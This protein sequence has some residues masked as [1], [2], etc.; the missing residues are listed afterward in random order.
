MILALVSM[1]V[2]AASSSLLYPLPPLSAETIPRSLDVMSDVV[3]QDTQRRAIDVE[4]SAQRSVITYRLSVDED[5]ALVDTVRSGGVDNDPAGAAYLT[6]GWVSLGADT[7]RDELTDAATIAGPVAVTWAPPQAQRTTSGWDIVFVAYQNERSPNP[8]ALRVLP[9]EA[10]PESDDECTTALEVRAP[11]YRFNAAYPADLVTASDDSTFSATVAEPLRLDIG[12]RQPTG[13]FFSPGLR[14]WMAE[15][16]RYGCV[17]APWVVLLW[18]FRTRRSL[19]P[20]PGSLD[21]GTRVLGVLLWGAVVGAFV[22]SQ[23]LLSAAGVARGS[24]AAVSAA[25]FVWALWAAEPGVR[26]A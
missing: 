14:T 16:W 26:T 21:L 3:V 25:L 5:S 13:D 8:A 23:Q 18:V 11:G 17:F 6:V 7:S 10:C 2:L 12:T 22:L 24:L 15:L 1:A 9:A 4:L 19:E 20:E